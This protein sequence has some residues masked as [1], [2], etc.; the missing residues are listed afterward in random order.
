[1]NVDELIEYCVDKEHNETWLWRQLYFRGGQTL[2]EKVAKDKKWNRSQII[3]AKNY[4]ES[5][6]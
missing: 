4:I 1:M 3:K 6:K 2:I 5:L